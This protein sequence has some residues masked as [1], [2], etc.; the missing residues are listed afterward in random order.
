[1]TLDPAADRNPE[2]LDPDAAFAGRV[3]SERAP[4]ALSTVAASAPVLVQLAR[5][6]REVRAGTD[7]PQLRDVLDGI[8]NGRA[9]LSALLADGVLPAPPSAMPDTLRKLWESNE[10]AQR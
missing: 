10:E 4:F 5:Q 1:M 2:P 3:S 8:L 6:M 9:P 7:D